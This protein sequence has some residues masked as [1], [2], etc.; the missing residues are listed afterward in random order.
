[1]VGHR[2][3]ALMIAIASFRVNFDLSGTG[4]GIFLGNGPPRSFVFA[5]AP[6]IIGLF[7]QTAHSTRAVL[8]LGFALG[9]LGNV[10]PI[11]ALHI[12][13]MVVGAILLIPQAE[14]RLW[15]AFAGSI[16]FFFGISPYILQRAWHLDATSLQMEILRFRVGDQCL[17][18]WEMV[19]YRIISSY[20]APFMLAGMGW[21]FIRSGE[22]REKSMWI[23]R[24][25]A[26]A[27]AWAAVG[28]IQCLAIPSLFALSLLRMSGYLFL[29]SLIL[30][31]F[32][33]RR[34]FEA[35]SSWATLTGY[36]MAA[37][38][39][40]SAG[41]GRVG[42]VVRL[43]TTGGPQEMPTL[44]VDGRSHGYG[45]PN[46]KAFMDMCLWARSATTPD[47]LFL[48]PPGPFASF[49]IYAQRP[50][51]VTFKDGAIAM[52]SGALADQWYARYQATE[53]LYQTFQPAEIVRFTSQHG[54]RYVIQESHQPKINLPIAYE[55]QGYRVYKPGT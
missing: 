10:H 48:A 28:P 54:I 18:S 25:A 55:N 36:G 53:L 45:V 44:W 52:F 47:D 3:A 6:W 16:G 15:L 43:V 27:V 23:A 39:V 42:E 38:L 1:M 5:A 26:V 13:L 33:L 24:L 35:R 50:L 49:R 7:I 41:G 30:S 19:G 37:F 4:W 34:L 22:E 31:G 32:L 29:F 46:K 51:F 11:S 2:L 9:I 21:I 14:S 40:L 8:G 17:P 20:A 12:Y